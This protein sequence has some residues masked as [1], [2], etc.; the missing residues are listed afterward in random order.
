MV[1]CLI[2]KSIS[3]FEFIFVYG[4]RVCCNFVDLHCGWSLTL[5]D[6]NVGAS[7]HTRL[8]LPFAPGSGQ[9]RRHPPF[10]GS[11]PLLGPRLWMDKPAPFLAPQDPP[12]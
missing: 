3:H 6:E 9:H 8:E 2:F 10:S 12:P 7:G 11:L 4:L 1:S 5:S